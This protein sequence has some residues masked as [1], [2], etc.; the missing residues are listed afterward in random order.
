MAKV[1]APQLVSFSH[2]MD[3]LSHR[4]QNVLQRYLD[5]AE[6]VQG[7]GT[8]TGAGGTANIQTS[9]EV[10]EA[11]TRIQTKFQQLNEV[12]RQAAQGYTSRDEDNAHSITAVAGG[13]RHI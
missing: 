11:Q 2:R 12:V 13:L 5:H 10:H 9:N 3:E 8:F 1:G 6:T 7:S 4:A